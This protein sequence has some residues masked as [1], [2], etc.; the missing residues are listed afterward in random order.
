MPGVSMIA[1]AFLG[2]VNKRAEGALRW[3]PRVPLAP[4]SEA[5]PG[6][7]QAAAARL[8]VG[9]ALRPWPPPGRR[10]GWERQSGEETK[11]KKPRCLPRMSDRGMKGKTDLNPFPK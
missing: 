9:G 3:E 10:R 5:R 8:W 6:G 11:L 4:S 2:P 7:A 1:P